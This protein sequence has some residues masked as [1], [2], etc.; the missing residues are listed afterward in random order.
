MHELTK[1]QAQKA[2]MSPT[3]LTNKSIVQR[4]AVKP[5]PVQQVPPIVQEVLV[6]SGQPL[7]ATTRTFI[8]SR[9]G[10]DFSQ[11]RVHANAQA[12]ES[13]R[14]VNALAYTVGN[15][16]VFADSQYAANTSAGHR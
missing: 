8:E 2:M 9:F 14:A 16:V 11:V 5:A 3:V 10:H 1:M 12:A 15:D 7:D 4:A 13:A 6:S